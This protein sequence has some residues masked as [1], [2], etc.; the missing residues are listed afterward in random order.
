MVLLRREKV[1]ALFRHG[2]YNQFEIARRILPTQDPSRPD[3]DYER[4]LLTMQVIVSKDLKWIRSQWRE[5]AIANFQEGINQ[6]VELLRDLYRDVK[7]Q[8][9][10]SKLDE[11]SKEKEYNRVRVREEEKDDGGNVVVEEQT[12]EVLGKRKVKRK[13]KAGDPALMAQM[14]SI[15]DKINSLLGLYPGKEQT[16]VIRGDRDEP[17]Q[18][19]HTVD[20]EAFKKL[21]LEDK[22]A[23]MRQ[24]AA[25]SRQ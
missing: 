17:V 9:E 22:V 18:V 25:G 21:S 1:A 5:T 2:V 16:L 24:Q 15:Q 6:Q 11:V 10:R 12:A 13:G 7:E 3:P 8:W 23:F 20:M 4:K 14:V 19:E